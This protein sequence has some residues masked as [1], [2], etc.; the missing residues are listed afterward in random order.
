VAAF[1]PGTQAGAVAELLF[2]AAEP[3]KRLDFEGRLPFAWP[4][5]PDKFGANLKALFPA[6]FG[7]SLHQQAKLAKLHERAGATGAD[8][9][10]LFNL[11]V[12]QGGWTLSLDD[13]GGARSA[14]GASFASPRNAL[15]A[16]AADLGQQENAIRLTWSGEEAGR[17]VLRHPPLDLTRDA[18]AA[19]CLALH[20]L[21]HGEQRQFT[22]RL[23]A[24]DGEAALQVDVPAASCE[25]A[26]A[27]IEIPLKAFGDG[28]LMTRVE[29]VELEA[30]SAFEMTLARLSVSPVAAGK[31]TAPHRR[32]P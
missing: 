32:L 29:A 4:Q 16:R 27:L 26:P 1:L 28:A 8:P 13:A 20:C 21:V 19:C 31:R 15:R 7:L 6:G 10:M 3:G 24:A 23:R 25:A 9:H 5:D 12:A 18:N 22:V 14:N 30:A 11:G 17:L 2:E